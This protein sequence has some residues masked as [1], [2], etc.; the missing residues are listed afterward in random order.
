MQQPPPGYPQY[1]Q[2]PYY[3]PQPPQKKGTSPLVIVL[4]VLGGILVLGF[5]GCLLCVGA[6][7]KGVADQAAKE[8][9]ESDEAKKSVMKVDLDDL[10][11]DYKGNEVAADKKYKGKFIEV[12]G[13]ARDIKKDLTDDMYVEVGTGGAFEIPAVHCDLGKKGEDVAAKLKKGQSIT[14]RG[15]VKGLMMDVQL[16]DCEV[17]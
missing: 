13:K 17:Q 10:L 6:G 5:G 1:P 2:Q 12:S 9:K 7:V 8:K 4:A 15:I 16:K 11:S 3:P 14:V